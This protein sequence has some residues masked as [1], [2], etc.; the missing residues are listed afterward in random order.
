MNP[1]QNP[2]GTPVDPSASATPV[3]SSAAIAA[4]KKSKTRRNILIAGSAVSLVGIGSTLAANI[5][6]NSGNNVEFGQ[7]VARATACD[8]DG[9]TITPITYFDNDIS[10]FRVERINVSGLN[11]TP[12][13]TGWNNGDLNGVYA[14]QDA[15]KAAHPAEYYDG[16]AHAWKRT[17]DGVVLDFKAYTDD[18]HYAGYTLDGYDNVSNTSINSPVM[19]SQSQGRPNSNSY[20]AGV[21][22]QIDVSNDND[23]N[24]YPLSSITFG[25]NNAKGSAV[26][27]WI[28]VW[29][30]SGNYTVDTSNA[31]QSN[32]YLWFD[33]N[34]AAPLADSI[35]KITVQSSATFSADYVTQDYYTN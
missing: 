19:W 20:N 2:D 24:N 23:L 3:V 33:G 29:S 28:Y 31:A 10:K 1:S 4:P 6:L 21:A 17:C 22:V 27:N 16:N 25:V 35:S 30:D 7:G 12:A 26:E 9:F 8:E 15:A 14:D 11:L 18:A 5:S 32:F 13:G 34:D